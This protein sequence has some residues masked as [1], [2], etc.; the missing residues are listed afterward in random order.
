MKNFFFLNCLKS[1]GTDRSKFEQCFLV[2][3][4][5]AKYFRF[6][7]EKLDKEITFINVF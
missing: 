4:H 7:L 1:K 2:V 5:H 6:L 3:T